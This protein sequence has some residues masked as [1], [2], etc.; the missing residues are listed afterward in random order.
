MSYHPSPVTRSPAHGQGFVG[1]PRKHT[2]CKPFGMGFCRLR[3]WEQGPSVGQWTC[4]DAVSAGDP[5]AL[6]LK[7]PAHTESSTSEAVGGESSGGKRVSE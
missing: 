4:R 6:N 3:I 7:C 2:E 1:R 5:P